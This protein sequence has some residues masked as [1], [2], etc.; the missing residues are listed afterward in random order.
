[1]NGDIQ[2]LCLCAEFPAGQKYIRNSKFKKETFERIAINYDIL[3]DIGTPPAK[4]PE[5]EVADEFFEP[6]GVRIC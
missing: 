1:L 6:K 2:L 4:Q 5:E 3:D